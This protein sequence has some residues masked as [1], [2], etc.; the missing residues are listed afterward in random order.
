MQTPTKEERTAARIQRR[1][2]RVISAWGLGGPVDPPEIAQP[3]TPKPPARKRAAPV[4]V[5][6]TPKRYVS[7][8]DGAAFAAMVHAGN[9][10]KQIAIDAGMSRQAVSLRA[11]S[12]GLRDRLREN[13]PVPKGRH[14]LPMEVI[15]AFQVQRS[16][17]KARGI[18]WQLSFAQWW[19]L[20]EAD[21]ERRGTGGDCLVMCRTGDKGPYA[22]GNVRIATVK[23]NAQERSLNR[24]TNSTGHTG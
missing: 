22:V 9:T 3:P 19:S 2:D 10:P 4:V 11:L 21:Y 15:K 16:G 13:K 7:K 12:L 1:Y 18:G 23:E 8:I 14:G 6:A 20:W 17:A 5:A 24:L